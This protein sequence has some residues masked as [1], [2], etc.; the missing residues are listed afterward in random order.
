MYVMA[1][2]AI[3][4][5]FGVFFGHLLDCVFNQVSM[6]FMILGAWVL[7]FGAMYFPLTETW[8]QFGYEPQ[9]FSC[10]IVESKGETFMP[11]M[12]TVGIGLPLALIIACYLAIHW[13]VKSTGRATRRAAKGRNGSSDVFGPHTMAAQTKERERSITITF[14]LISL[15][16]IICFLPY[17]F[18]SLVDPMPPSKHGWLHMIT[19][20]LAW[21]SAFV[22]PVIYCLA[23]KYYLETF[24][25]FLAQIL[26]RVTK[27]KEDL[28]DSETV[29][30]METEETVQELLNNSL[31][32][33]TSFSTH[34]IKGDMTRIVEI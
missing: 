33:T 12:S 27:G 21:T 26:E 31:R 3:H 9:T 34:G 7:S 30:S 8:G 2:I 5:L 15:S 20:I 10:T 11:L 14:S 17:S 29:A 19:Y 18:I 32:Q 6:L 25:Q 22:N 23:N 4:R 16:F 24:R 1:L 13:K 28:K